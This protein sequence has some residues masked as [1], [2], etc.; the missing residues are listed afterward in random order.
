MM[1]ISTTLLLSV[2]MLALTVASARAA[3]RVHTGQWETTIGDG[4]HARVLKGC[5]SAADADAMNGNEKA[6]RDSLV[7]A[8]AATGCTVG[9]VKIS[10]NQVI[11]NSVC[12]GKQMTSTTTYHGDSYEQVS[13]NGTKVRAVRIGACS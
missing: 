10:G 4:A 6:F 9:D 3:D 11:S 8:T 12:H 13:S 7:K 5:L 2:A 1:H